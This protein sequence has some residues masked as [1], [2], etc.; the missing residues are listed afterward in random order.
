MRYVGDP[1]ATDIDGSLR[2]YKVT[3]H[4]VM[5]QCGSRYS[6]F[7]PER[8][9]RCSNRMGCDPRGK[10]LG[11]PGIK[12]RREINRGLSVRKSVC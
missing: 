6:P 5:K 2:D 4:I 11:E 12:A 1:Q 7:P 3:G 8:V 10:Y 9:I